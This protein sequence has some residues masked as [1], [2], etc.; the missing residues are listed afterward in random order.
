MHIDPV[1]KELD[2]IRSRLGYYG[3]RLTGIIKF[4][5]S[6]DQGST[7]NPEIPEISEVVEK[8]F[9]ACCNVDPPDTRYND[10]SRTMATGLYEAYIDWCT[11]ENVQPESQRFFGGEV[12]KWF[13]R[14]KVNGLTQYLG[15][16]LKK[17]AGVD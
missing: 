11:R 17:R 12:G 10:L 1:I 4:L 6:T 15:L 14:R 8:F 16:S 7:D 5:N 9:I 2:E 13:N 3:R